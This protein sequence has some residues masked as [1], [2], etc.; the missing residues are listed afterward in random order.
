MFDILYLLKRVAVIKA[1]QIKKNRVDVFDIVPIGAF[2][3]DKVIG[4]TY[5]FADWSALCEI[6]FIMILDLIRAHLYQHNLIS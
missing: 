3:Y 6:D 4:A 5:E 1:S 2:E